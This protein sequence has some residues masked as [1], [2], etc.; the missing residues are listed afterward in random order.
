[1]ISWELEHEQ[2]IIG[3]YCFL[4][5]DA[6]IH[7]VDSL[8]KKKKRER[9]LIIEISSIENLFVP[10]IK[11]FGKRQILFLKKKLVVKFTSKF[12]FMKFQFMNFL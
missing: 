12:Q 11:Y 4:D 3:L 2:E 7:L 5:L 1:M 8:I 6:K 10:N 9:N